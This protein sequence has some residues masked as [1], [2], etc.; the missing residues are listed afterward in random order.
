MVPQHMIL[1]HPGEY[2]RLEEVKKPQKK[3]EG[4]IFLWPSSFTLFMPPNVFF[5]I[6]VV[7][8]RAL[9]AEKALSLLHFRVFYSYRML[10]NNLNRQALI[11]EALSPLSPLPLD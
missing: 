2:W 11:D 9:S 8:T 7:Q 1:W 4:D 3:K 10:Q 6:D 5:V